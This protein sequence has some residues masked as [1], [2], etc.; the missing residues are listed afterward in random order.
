MAMNFINNL[1]GLTT[2]VKSSLILIL[3]FATLKETLNG[4]KSNFDSSVFSSLQSVL[5]PSQ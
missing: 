4:C 2:G 5:E 1:R 3:I